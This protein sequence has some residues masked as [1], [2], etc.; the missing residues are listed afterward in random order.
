MDKRAAGPFSWGVAVCALVDGSKQ[1]MTV[2]NKL[3]YCV[4]YFSMHRERLRIVEEEESKS[5]CEKGRMHI[6][7][8]NSRRTI[9][10]LVW[11]PT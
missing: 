4:S 10:T 11:W 7:S 2:L 3:G 9:L 8:K 5:N 1:L 6:T